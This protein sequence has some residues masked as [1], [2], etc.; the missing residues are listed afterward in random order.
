MCLTFIQT[1]HGQ[2]IEQFNWVAVPEAAGGGGRVVAKCECEC[3]QDAN[4][5]F[6]PGHDQRLRA[7]LERRVGGLLALRTLVTASEDYASGK[8]T[9]QALTRTVRSILFRPVQK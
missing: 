9:E 7:A 3:G 1:A 2:D 5:D 4:G 8:E 6:L